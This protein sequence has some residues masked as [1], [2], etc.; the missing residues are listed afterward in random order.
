M[1]IRRGAAPR[2]ERPAS[3]G[4]RPGPAARG[5]FRR[6]F[7]AVQ[8][9]TIGFT[10]S[11]AEH[12]FGRLAAARIGQLLDVRLSNS[13][14]L[15]GFAKAQDLPYLLRELVGAGYRHEPLLAPTKELL[16]SQKKQKGDWHVFERRFESLLAE[17]QIETRLS[18]ADFEPRTALLCSEASAERC[19]RRLV[20]DYLGLHWRGVA[21]VHL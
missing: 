18:P 6:D 7:A 1:P 16:D 15:A 13:S 19:H 14:Q 9:W 20:C 21:A 8:I 5:V 17:R 2:P 11:T 12:F 4:G 10:Q 3:A